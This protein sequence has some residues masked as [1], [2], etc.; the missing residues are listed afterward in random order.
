MID[1]PAKAAW[2]KR[3][4]ELK[5]VLLVST[6]AKPAQREQVKWSWFAKDFRAISAA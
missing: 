3:A 1:E 5:P 6:D 2:E 4:D